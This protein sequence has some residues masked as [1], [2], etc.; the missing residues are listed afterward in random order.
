MGV[1]LIWAG[2]RTFK[3][4]KVRKQTL[5]ERFLKEIRE[6]E[7]EIEDVK[8]FRERIKEIEELEEKAGME[9]E[10]LEKE[11]WEKK[12]RTF[13]PPEGPFGRGAGGSESQPSAGPQSE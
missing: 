9:E 8:K 11:L 6:A 10:R 1:I 4:I 13:P 5:R 2:Y 12:T 3:W 7:K